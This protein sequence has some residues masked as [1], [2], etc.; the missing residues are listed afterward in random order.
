MRTPENFCKCVH[1]LV[2]ETGLPEVPW[3]VAGSGFLV[4][5]Q[6]RFFLLTA[7]HALRPDA[8]HPICIKAPSGKTMAIRDVFYVPAEDASDEF[9]DLAILEIDR[10]QA[11]RECRDAR[12]LPLAIATGD[13]KGS[14]FASEFLVVGFPNEHSWVEYELREVAMGL[15]ELRARY[16]G[17]TASE[18]I[19]ELRVFEPPP[20]QSFSGFSGAPVFMWKRHMGAESQLLLCGMAI[21]GTIE[22]ALVRFIDVSTILELLNVRCER[23]PD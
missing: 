16:A 13:W 10:Q 17:P 19:H 2:F 15:V 7:R 8:L 3:T 23:A 20:L 6:L 18:A 12:I 21:Q 4:E 1:A 11:I 5:H 14:M 9:F 22:S